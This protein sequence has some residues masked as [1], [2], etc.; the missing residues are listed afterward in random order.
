M[1]FQFLRSA[2]QTIALTDSISSFFSSMLAKGPICLSG[3]RLTK[4]P[5]FLCKSHPCQN[6]EKQ[7]I[8]SCVN[9]PA[10][11]ASVI[12]YSSYQLRISGKLMG[13]TNLSHVSVPF[14]SPSRFPHSLNKDSLFK[15]ITGRCICRPQLTLSV[16]PF[17][18]NRWLRIL[19]SFWMWHHFLSYRAL[20]ASGHY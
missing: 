5:F 13:C 19:Q 20:S 15:L 4:M 17:F 10:W 6:K 2:V 1:D 11:K 16:K 8:S 3:P 18:Q 14:I 7:Q 9:C 12:W